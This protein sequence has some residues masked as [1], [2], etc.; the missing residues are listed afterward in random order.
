LLK[1]VSENGLVVHHD[2]EDGPPIEITAKCSGAVG[3]QP[4]LAEIPCRRV[5]FDRKADP[6]VAVIDAWDFKQGDWGFS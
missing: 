3:T 6:D 4:P 5:V 2:P 1:G